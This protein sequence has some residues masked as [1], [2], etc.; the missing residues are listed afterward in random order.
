MA[1]IELWGTG[2]IADLLGV[3]RSRADQLSRQFGF[4]KPYARAF[5][6]RLWRKSEIVKW[7][8]QTGRTLNG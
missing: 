6:R 4:P 8:K 5:G 7:A 3:S 1:P 2:D